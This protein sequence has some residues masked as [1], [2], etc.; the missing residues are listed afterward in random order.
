MA[1]NH[2][3]S[4]IERV[5]RRHRHYWVVEKTGEA[6]EV[7]KGTV[8]TTEVRKRRGEAPEVVKEAVES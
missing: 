3:V 2:D 4:S 5:V 6:A 7:A 1:V 8:E